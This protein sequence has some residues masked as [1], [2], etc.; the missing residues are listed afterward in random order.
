[1]AASQPTTGSSPPAAAAA[2]A[3]APATSAPQPVTLEADDEEA[4]L[5]DS[6]SALG[7][8]NGSSTTSLASSI[9]KYRLE[10]GRT[11]HAYKDGKYVFPNDEPEQ[12]RLDLQHHICSITFD[13]RLFSCPIDAASTKRVL[14]VG[15]GTGI[16]VTDYADEWP[17]ASV[18]GI[19]LSPIQPAFVP[20]N[21]Q[22]QVD[23]AE[24]DW[25]FGESFDFIYARMMTGS[26]QNWD[27]F[28]DQCYKK[29]NHNFIL[30]FILQ[31]WGFRTGGTKRYDS[32]ELIN[33]TP[34][35][36]VELLDICL[37]FES[38]DDTL[39]KDSAL[40]KW[41]QLLLEGSV[42]AGRDLNSCLKYKEQLTKRG[43]VNVTETVY[44]WPC[45]KWPKDAKAKELGMWNL[46]NLSNGL[47]GLS[48]ATFTRL[49][50]WTVDELE[51]FLVD[52]RKDLKDTKIHSYIPIYVV[53]AQRPEES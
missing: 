29:K 18:L 44:K 12:E 30:Y 21:A 16:W 8:E 38:A 3:S 37:P 27:R 34:G 19:D 14:D 49:L 51:V 28:F 2:A 4:L 31:S 6:D 35:G 11:Y 52:V 10:N 33:M 20:P 23:D 32:Q 17:Q 26:L 53:Y 41:S 1:M 40:L 25:T 13:G 46:E 24:E 36:W 22:F 50:G 48:I 15:C 43:F 39:K 7:S 47:S 9:T 45:N 42:K 5:D